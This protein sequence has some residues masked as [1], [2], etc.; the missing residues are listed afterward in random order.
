M[1]DRD[2]RMTYLGLVGVAWRSLSAHGLRSTLTMIGVIVGVGSMIAVAAIGAGAREA[3]TQQIR[4]LGSDLTIV[5]SGSG[6]QS[7]LKLGAGATSNLS[8]AD[9][10]AISRDVESVAVSSP[11]LRTGAQAIGGGRNASTSVFGADMRFLVARDWLVESGRGFDLSEIQQAAPVALLGRTVVA[12]L[13][14]DA[15]PLDEIVVVRDVPL[16]VL[17]VLAPK[18]QSMVAQDQDDAVIV[19]IGLARRRFLEQ[20]PARSSGDGVGAILVKGK[21]GEDLDRTGADIRTLLRQR[22]KLFGDQDDDFQIRNLTEI[23]NAVASSANEISVLL[24]AVAGISLFVGGVGIMNMMLVSV[25]E[26]VP[27]IG[28]RLAVGATRRLILAQFLMEAAL[29]AAAG[30]VAGTLIGWALSTFA[31]KLA[32]WPVLIDGGQAVEA[33]AFSAFVGVVFGFAPALRASRLDPIA[34]LRRA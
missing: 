11:F 34:A 30:G 7:G 10:D 8:E 12:N 33:V 16:R 20:G 23:M 19:P 18:G 26:R 24:E 32:D 1:R 6:F 3:V 4:S 2:G 5:T 21:K 17:G 28:L 27:E 29:L 9:A 22:H 15:D 14:G 13:F 31:A 25:S